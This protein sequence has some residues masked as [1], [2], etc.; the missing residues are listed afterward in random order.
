MLWAELKNNN[1]E[2]YV[3]EVDHWDQALSTGQWWN[4]TLHVPAA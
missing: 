1:K 3:A 2:A 4:S